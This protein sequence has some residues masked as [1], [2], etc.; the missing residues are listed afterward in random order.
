[1]TT[2]KWTKTE[3]QAFT[4]SPAVFAAAQE[5]KAMRKI[6]SAMM[7]IFEARLYEQLYF[8]RGECPNDEMFGKF[9]VAELGMTA[10]DAITK[11]DHWAIARKNRPLRELAQSSGR[12]MDTAMLVIGKLVD[13]DIMDS[14]EDDQ[15]RGLL[16]QPPKKMISE[17]RRLIDRDPSAE[18]GGER[19]K[20]VERERDTALEQVAALENNRETSPAVS[21]VTSRIA[22][23]E[24]ELSQLAASLDPAAIAADTLAGQRLLRAV[25][26][27]VAVL[28]EIADTA[29]RD[30]SE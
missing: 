4:P 15:V 2:A 14:I 16:A 26:S 8:I 18:A 21:A 27:A 9:A 17:I 13:A 11:A 1:M 3:L 7:Q 30:L 29:S 19:L 22:E 28:D 20:I 25:D 24:A 23:F 6:A 10:A 12:G 5:I